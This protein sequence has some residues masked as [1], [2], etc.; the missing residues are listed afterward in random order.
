MSQASGLLNGHHA[1]QV[2]SQLVP[3][4]T[5]FI[6]LRMDEQ[7]G[8]ALEDT[9]PTRPLRLEDTQ[10]TRPFRPRPAPGRLMA[11]GMVIVLSAAS[12]T[13][14]VHFALRPVV[15][16]TPTPDARPSLTTVTL[17]MS[18]QPRDIHTRATTVGALL[19]EQDITLGPDDGLSDPLNAPLRHGMTL[20]IN[21]A[22]DL[23]LIVNEE[24][25]RLRTPFTYPLDILRD[26][27]LTLNPQDRVW[28][29]GEEITPAQLALW[30][31]APQT[32]RIRRA[33]PV[34]I[35]DAG[36]LRTLHTAVDTVG[37]VLFEAGVNLF[38][39]DA[40]SPNLNTPIT[41]EMQIIIDR[42]S[43]VT[44]AA[45]GGVLETRVQGGT[46]ADALAAA[47]VP[48]VGQDYTVP[49]ENTRIQPGMNV[50]VVRVSQDILTTDETLPYE[51]VYQADP[52]LELDQRQ[53]RQAG[54]AGLRQIQTR[55]RYEDGLEVGREV[56]RD[57]IVRAPVNEVIAYGTNI[58]L[59]SIDTP[60]GARQYWRKL[61]VYATA[62]YPEALGGDDITAIGLTLEKGIIGADPTIIPYRTGMYVPG[63][64]TGIMADTGGPRSSP[65][66]ID[67]GYSDDDWQA[68]HHYVDVYLLTPVPDNI[69]YL[70]PTWR[71]M[72]GLPDR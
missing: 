23:Q 18:G 14:T 55:V 47:N 38:L 43:P 67:L 22:R 33:M 70:L 21:R 34:T 69:N 42:A 13:W 44:I 72:A 35:V 30:E 60:E 68:W 5:S 53:R 27:E 6:L 63:Y 61:R 24:T 29:D 3:L 31:R 9:Q 7:R 57:E 10:P 26:A 40:V 19:N 56:I 51:T 1:F 37:D 8:Y 15:A 64:G 41:P 28:I 25:R 11:L 58:V 12:L 48:L 66:W 52:A 16:P 59:R 54:Q 50:R 4:S 49:P 62:Y 36:H 45:D 39:A 17:F 32:L 2:I 46:I 65:Y 71:P 20:Y